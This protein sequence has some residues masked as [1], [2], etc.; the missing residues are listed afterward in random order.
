[1]DKIEIFNEIFQLCIIPLL[2]IL[3]KYVVSFISKKMEEAS[4]NID[5]S[6]ATKYINLLTDTINDCIIATNQTYVNT[7]K[8]QNA[9]TE[10]AQKEAL[11]MTKN[12]V[13]KILTEDAKEYL[14]QIY[15]DLNELITVK[16][17][18]MIGANK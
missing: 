7:L 12:E 15:G 14:T 11:E 6:L 5:N 8:D 17:E 10:E 13:L 2:G 4:H 9:F 18:S 16:I 3:T 1:M